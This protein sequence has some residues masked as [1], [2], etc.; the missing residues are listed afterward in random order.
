MTLTLSDNAGKKLYKRAGEVRQAWSSARCQAGHNTLGRPP[1]WSP[2]A[3]WTLQ[4][5]SWCRLQTHCSKGKCC[6][7]L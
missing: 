4:R 2:A 7:A 1:P 6:Y 3:W 5:M